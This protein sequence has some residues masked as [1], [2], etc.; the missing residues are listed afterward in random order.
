MPSET[1]V[2]LEELAAILDAQ[3]VPFVVGGPPS[4]VPMRST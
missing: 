1:L 4:A 2:V 3:D